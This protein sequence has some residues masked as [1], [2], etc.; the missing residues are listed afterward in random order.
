MDQ[1]S[2]AKQ[3]ALI[4]YCL[5]KGL[6]V[7]AVTMA[8][9]WITNWAMLHQGGGDWMKRGDREEVEQALGTAMKRQRGEPVEVP[10]WLDLLPKKDE[11][12]N[13][14]DQLGQL[15]NDLAH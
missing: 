4:V 1:E 2:L 11:I 10:E 5:E 6:V 9:E 15:R 8:R 12:I 7:Q 13:A 3:Q 14:W